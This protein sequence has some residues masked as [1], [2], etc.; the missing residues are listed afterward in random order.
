MNRILKEASAEVFAYCLM[1]NHFHLAIRVGPVALASVMHRLLTSYSLVFNRRHDRAGHLFQ[2]R[3]KA[4]LCLNDAYLATLIRYIH[5]NPVR[6]GLVSRPQDWRW[7][8]FKGRSE[9]NDY[10]ADLADFDPWP[11]QTAENADLTREEDKIGIADLGLTVAARTGVRI[12]ELRSDIRCRRVVEAK[13]LLARDAFK[14]GHSLMAIGR[15][16]NAAPSSVSRYV[17]TNTGIRQA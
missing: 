7:S 12:D 17:R 16:L 2:A 10:E 13:R 5:L 3:Y 15:W 14:S 6:A 4:I 11:K 9:A 8:S 1:G